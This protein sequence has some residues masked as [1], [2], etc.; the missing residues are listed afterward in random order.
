MSTRSSGS[1]RRQ[2]QVIVRKV[3]SA[4]TTIMDPATPTIDLFNM[5]MIYDIRVDDEARVTVDLA[6]SS[7][8]LPGNLELPKRVADTVR[9][10]DGVSECSV[11]VVSDPPWTMDRVTEYARIHLS[12]VGGSD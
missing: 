11:K 9:E 7:P 1:G 8:G 4:M 10:I 3:Q 2:Q 5:G 6:F 12:V